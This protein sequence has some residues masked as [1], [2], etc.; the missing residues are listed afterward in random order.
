[1]PKRVTQ[2]ELEPIAAAL[3][4]HPAGLALTQLQE[5]LRGS[6]S[7]R[8]LS[9]RI[10]ALTA[11]GRIHRRG[12]GRSARY[13]HGPPPTVPRH[14]PVERTGRVSSDRTDGVAPAGRAS[15]TDGR[16]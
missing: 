6:I 4:R 14:Q 3:L 15:E 2:A 7:R 1:M 9:R 13:L 10:S 8:T 5:E 12:E 16:F 11:A